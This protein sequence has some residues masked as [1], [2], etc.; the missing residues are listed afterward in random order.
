MA[1]RSISIIITSYNQEAYLREAI[2]SAL[3]Q[4]VRPHEII[5]ADDHS[6]RDNSVALIRDYQTRFPGLVRG[7]FQEEN[8]FIPRN[9]NAALATVTSEFVTMLDG[10][11][12]LLPNFIERHLAALATN[13]RAGCSYSNRYVMS[14]TG[15]R[16]RVHADA[17]KPSGNIFAQVARGET[18]ILR[19]L[20]ARIDLIRA[21][22]FL[23]PEC[24]HH[25]GYILSLRLAKTTEFVYIPEP[26]MEKREHPGGTSRGTS[27][28]KK[29]R[30]QQRAFAETMMLSADLPRR[31]RK[32]IAWQ[33]YWNMLEARVMTLAE[34][35]E[36]PR[37]Y[38]AL[39]GALVR[40]PT[41]R[42]IRNIAE[43]A[44]KI[45]RGEIGIDRS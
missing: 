35:G 19:T 42:R 1:A 26:L 28:A 40:S 36:R 9:R 17:Q 20:V 7:V 29:S 18:G 37:A 3:H 44:R 33:W 43:F 25:D 16:L 32:A 5:V 21:A 31:E 15:E 8:V 41:R 10:D 14:P 27:P 34:A 6:T 4:T 39:A 12:R 45:A 11:D 30:S 2:D 38:A 22:G 23:D 24:R 13:P